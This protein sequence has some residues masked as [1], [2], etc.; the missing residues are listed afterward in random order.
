[1]SANK[2]R[3]S[4]GRGLD[5]LFGETAEVAPVTVAPYG[6]LDTPPASQPS[7]AVSKGLAEI[8]VEHMAPSRFQPRRV[9]NETQ[10]DE[11]AASIRDKGVL[12]P[13]LVRSA[14]DGTY[15]IIAGER[16]WRAAQR[17]KI[18]QV[19]VIIK[20]FPDPEVLEVA[21]VE[22]LQ[23]ADL[24]PLEEA[25]GYQRLSDEFGHTQEALAKVLGKSRGHV[26]NMIR[27]LTLPESVKHLLDR[28]SL[29]MGQARALIGVADAGDLAKQILARGL[30][31]RQVEKLVKKHGKVSR[32]RVSKVAQAAAEKDTDT[33]DLENRLEEALGLKAEVSFDGKGGVL[34]LS[35]SDLE[36]LDELVSRLTRAKATRPFVADRDPNVLDIEEVLAK[37]GGIFKLGHSEEERVAR[38]QLDPHQDGTGSDGSIGQ[39]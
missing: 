27:L 22:N 9:F 10:I 23:R 13:L 29:S 36:Q 6:Q 11:L 26:A 37:R 19:P 34:S 17:A 20:E 25:E 15:E 21:L 4:L 32:P 12:Q 1:M 38:P 30:S 24:T 39:E 31:V 5:A 3:Q 8:P 16:R 7:V 18:H 28:G 33:R 2:P 14:P 35:Y